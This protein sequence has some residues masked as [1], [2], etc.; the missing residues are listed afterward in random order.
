MDELQAFLKRAIGVPFKEKGR[1]PDGWDCWGLVCCFYKTVFGIEIP[2]YEDD[3]LSAMDVKTVI[4][5]FREGVKEWTKFDL[6]FEK[7]G[8][9]AIIRPNHAGVVITSG[10]M[11]HCRAGIETCIERYDNSI[12]NKRIMGFYRHVKLA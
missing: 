2:S 9:V 6:S 7:F 10:R 11:L 12:W 5:L 3:Y 8:D 4:R 1:D